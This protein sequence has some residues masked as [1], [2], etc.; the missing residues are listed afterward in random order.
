MT[1]RKPLQA[2]TR[3]AVILPPTRPNIGIQAAYQS[4]LDALI[5]E[6]DGSIAYWLKAAWRA[7]PPH[8]P[9]AQDVMPITGI[10]QALERLGRRWQRNFD[11]AAPK[12]AEWFADRSMGRAEKGFTKILDDA[13]WTVKFRMTKEARQAYRAVIGEN[14]GLIKSIASQHLHEVQGVVYQSVL[15]GRDL[16][17]V[18]DALQERFGVTRSR[19]ALIA[20]DQN[21]KAT[22][23]VVR[24]RQ[25]EL[26]ITHARWKHSHAGIHPRPSHVAA[27]GKIYPIA[28]GMYL[29]GKWVLPGEEINC[30]C[31]SESVIPGL[32]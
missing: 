16:G 8:A 9:M 30:R 21:N 1:T 25:D 15:A 13:G 18:T 14:V 7:A 3:R 29:D 11:D 10:S 6:M 31:C 20:R 2:P 32:E 28:K 5:E 27:D 22:A 26:G 19:A 24:T 12:L 4:R 23:I 17:A